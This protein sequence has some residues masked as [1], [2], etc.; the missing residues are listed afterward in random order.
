MKKT[1]ALL[2]ACLLIAAGSSFAQSRP[3]VDT[4]AQPTEAQLNSPMFSTQGNTPH[5]GMTSSQLTMQQCQDLAAMQRNNPGMDR[6]AGQDEKA[7]ASLMNRK[8]AQGAAA[9]APMSQNDGK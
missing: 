8:G 7:C 5:D 2:C 6:N 3:G 9:D 4:Q 1:H